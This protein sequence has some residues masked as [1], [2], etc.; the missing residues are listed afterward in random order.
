MGGFSRIAYRLLT[1]H[2]PGGFLIRPNP[3]I[4]IGPVDLSSSFVV[5]DARQYDFPIVY[6]SPTFER[7]TGYTPAEVIGHNCRFLQAP[8]GRVVP[9]S[10][11]RYTDNETIYHIKTHIA[12]GKESQSSVVNYRK[13]GQP[14]VNLLTIIPIACESDDIDFLVGLQVDL[15]EQPN[16]IIQSMKGS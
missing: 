1:P 11:R 5:V 13:N 12:Q 14:F 7:L 4:N 6:A 9:G 2:P 8:D 10:R 3:Q 15:V 16:A